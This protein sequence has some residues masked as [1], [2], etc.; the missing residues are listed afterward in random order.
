VPTRRAETRLEHRR[1][2]RRQESLAIDLA[3]WVTPLVKVGGGGFSAAATLALQSP[4][5]TPVTS[6][7]AIVCGSIEESP[8]VTIGVV[9]S[10]L[11]AMQVSQS[12]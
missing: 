5:S 1:P 4:V 6:T 11:S 12:G 3:S 10:Q 9:Y 2:G 8:G 7:V